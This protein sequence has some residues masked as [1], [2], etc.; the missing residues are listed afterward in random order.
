MQDDMCNPLKQN[1]M[2]SP[3]SPL[4]AGHFLISMHCFKRKEKKRK[5][6]RTQALFSLLHPT[7][8]A[9]RGRKQILVSSHLPPQF[10]LEKESSPPP[11]RN[12]KLGKGL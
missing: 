10:K 2:V 1:P 7:G 5:E 11:S 3:F 4:I 12:H 8:P 9:A 6:R